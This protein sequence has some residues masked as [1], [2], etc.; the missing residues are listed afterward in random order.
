M[1]KN[2]TGKLHALWANKKL[3]WFALA[4][5]AVIVIVAA[6]MLK[7]GAKVPTAIVEERVLEDSFY[8]DGDVRAQTRSAVS[9]EFSGKVQKVYVREGQVVKK[10]DPLFII[11]PISLEAE[12]KLLLADR[13]ALIAT[14][15]QSRE[16]I[17][18]QIAAVQAQ[19]AGYLAPD[20]G[21]ILGAQISLFDNALD[22]SAR[23]GV[24]WE[25]RQMIDMTTQRLDFV[26]EQLGRAARRVPAEVQALQTQLETA[27]AQGMSIANQAEQYAL[28][29]Q[30]QIMELEGK[31]AAESDP[32]LQ[33]QY[34]QMIDSLRAGGISNSYSSMQSVANAQVARL[35]GDIALARSQIPQEVDALQSQLLALESEL[36]TLEEQY[37]AYQFS[38]KSQVL[39]FTAQ[40]EQAAVSLSASKQAR[41]KLKEQIALLEKSLEDGSPTASYYAA[42]L[43]KVNINIEDVDRRI[44][45]AKVNAPIGGVVGAF[46]LNEGQFVQ[47]G[48]VLTEVVDPDSLL[49]ECMLLTDDANAIIDTTPVEIIWERRDGDVPFSGDIQ[50]ISKLAVNAMS[51]VGLS[52]QRVKALIAPAFSQEAHPGDGYRVR[53]KFITNS[54]RALSVPQKALIVTDQ[55]DAVFTV[56]GG[57]A[58]LTHITLG[59]ETGTDAAVLSGLKQGD[60]V[61]SN[62][63]NVKEGDAIG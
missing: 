56:Q 25:F 5:V 49:I 54:A 26:S 18:Q 34:Q 37:A 15:E 24:A 36:R 39:A 55:G 22:P 13:D 20:I 8:E 9:L 38:T 63:E 44:T 19:R 46:N 45:L 17:K 30:S 7:G 11:D 61:I 14:W 53:V 28:Q 59:M 51:A 60:I 21:G 40:Q 48:A 32:T 57:K 1:K 47:A 42:Q 29:Q 16:Q 43:Q 41:G 3:R 4:L 10:G 27:Q 2:G 12:K 35:Q 33:A 50:D 62:P 31:L 58:T 6:V 23:G 52:E